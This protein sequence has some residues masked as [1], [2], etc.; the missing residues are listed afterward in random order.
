MRTSG[1][2]TFGRIRPKPG[3][4][5]HVYSHRFCS[6]LLLFFNFW[7]KGG[8]SSQQVSS[9]FSQRLTL[10]RA[11]F[12]LFLTKDGGALRVSLLPVSPKEWRLD[13]PR[14]ARLS[15]QTGRE[16]TPR[17]AHFSQRAEERKD[18]FAHHS[19]LNLRR[20][21]TTLRII[22]SLTQGRTGATL[23]IIPS[24]PRGEQGPLCAE[25]YPSMVREVCTQ[26]GTGGV[27]QHGREGSVY[28]A[29]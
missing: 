10:R 3:R 27:Y 19:L 24:Y 6:F 25:G 12:S 26:H 23:R 1:G 9:S 29:W 28:P 8:P 5:E 2:P 7:K 14:Y 21:R 15:H 17:Y 4:K 20:R 18:H 11:T 22:L 16:D 13:T